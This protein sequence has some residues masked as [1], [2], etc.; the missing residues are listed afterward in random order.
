M[1]TVTKKPLRPPTG[2]CLVREH[3][4]GF[5]WLTRSDGSWCSTS[6]DND[7]TEAPGF[8]LSPDVTPDMREI[9][10]VQYPGDRISTHSVDMIDYSPG[11]ETPARLFIA[12][13]KMKHVAAVDFK[14]GA[15]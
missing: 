10:R 8:V 6:V 5:D 9:A 12:R 13:L 11:Q 14:R 1:G 15:A 3:E 7:P 2:Y 4:R